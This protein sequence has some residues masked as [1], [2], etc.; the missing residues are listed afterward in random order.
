MSV[1]T[2]KT[3]NLAELDEETGGGG[4]HCTSMD[5]ACEITSLDGVSDADLQI[6]VDAHVAGPEDTRTVDEK[7]AQ[8]GLTI[9]ELSTALGL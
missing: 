5:G 2:N 6:A 4:L 7:L 1:T 3:I 9:A 8:A